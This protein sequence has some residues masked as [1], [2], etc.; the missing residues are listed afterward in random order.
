MQTKAQ[1]MNVGVNFMALD[2]ERRRQEHLLRELR[3]IEGE[4][5]SPALKNTKLPHLAATVGVS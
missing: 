4:I 1:E 5:S 2:D 3:D